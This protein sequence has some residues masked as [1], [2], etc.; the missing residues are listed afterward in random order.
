[1]FFSTKKLIQYL[2]KR[3]RLLL[4]L[5]RR[6]EDIPHKNNLMGMPWLTLHHITLG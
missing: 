6:V 4:D 2:L 3:W 1:M 5:I